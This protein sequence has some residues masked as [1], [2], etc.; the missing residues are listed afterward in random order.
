M[1]ICCALKIFLIVRGNHVP[2]FTIESLAITMQ[3]W[4]LTV[5]TTVRTPADSMCPCSSYSPVAANAPT[6][7]RDVSG[8]N[9]RSSQLRMVSLFLECCLAIALSEPARAF[10]SRRRCS[11]SIAFKLASRLEVESAISRS[12]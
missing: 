2:L 7:K 1:P 10:S 12:T 5:P 4:S 8:S 6:S 3:S 11:S 9:S